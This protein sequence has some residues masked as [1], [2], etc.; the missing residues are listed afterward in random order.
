MLDGSR[1]YITGYIKVLGFDE[2]GVFAK[3]LP[4]R[5]ATVWVTANGHDLPAVLAG[6]DGK[7]TAYDTYDNTPPA[8]VNILVAA[9]CSAY[10][11]MPPGAA[12]PAQAYSVSATG[13]TN[14]IEAWTAGQSGYDVFIGGPAENGGVQAGATTVINAFRAYTLT[15]TFRAFATSPSGLGAQLN[16]R[17]AIQFP[18][19]KAVD[20]FGSSPP[21]IYLTTAF[22]QYPE[23]L[24][25][26]FG[27]FVSYEASLG[28]SPGGPHAANYNGR[29]YLYNAGPPVVSQSGNLQSLSLPIEQRAF[30]EGW[31]DVFAV[32]A[33]TWA[34][35]N[36]L[37]FV[38][39]WQPGSSY[40]PQTATMRAE[41]EH[42]LLELGPILPPAEAQ[43]TSFMEVQP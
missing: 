9:S 43:A 17:L 15:Y 37:P 2:E 36:Q 7:Y 31:A 4:V 27:H 34:V 14:H 1:C 38:T 13:V 24:G 33:V 21:T 41:G 32:W 30:Q 19:A 29:Y 40:S 11:V 3:A 28:Y 18:Y 10:Y 12:G 23:Y 8:T 25:H 35:A 16:D 26:E 5:E 20:Q 42:A 39:L 22:I 6:P